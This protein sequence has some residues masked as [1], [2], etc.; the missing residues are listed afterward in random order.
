MTNVLVLFLDGVGL[1]KP[2]PQR[3]PFVLAQMPTLQRL[4]EGHRLVAGVAPID[5]REA[6]LLALDATLG[7]DGSP[8]S[9]SGQATLLTGLNV[10]AHIGE[11]YGPKP[12]PPIQ[13]IL[14]ADNLFKQVLKH[15]HT[16]A[17]LNAY[18]PGYFASI[19][20]GRRLYSAIPFAA[21]AAGLPLMTAA[22]LQSGRALSVDFTGEGWAA[23]P[24]F[25]PAPVYGA[26]HAGRL[27]AEL[28]SGF[29]LAWFD[30]WPSDYAGHKQDMTQAVSL[31]ERFDSV[32][33]GLVEAWRGEE[34]LIAITSDHGNLEDLGQRNHTRNLVPGLFIGPAELRQRFS[35]GMHDLSDFAP[36][37]MRLLLEGQPKAGA[38][39]GDNEHETGSAP[40]GSRADQKRG[41]E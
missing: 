8:Q 10:P 2:D 7:V 32:M 19:D 20:S 18:P 24:G 39:N 23:Q 38:G 22:D 31:L 33:A 11:H 25:P 41:E 5:G 30:F 1:G 4:L 9:A 13:D 36:A 14:E 21:N 15:G 12:N 27:L 37:V 6:T 17:L 3:N 26:K 29:D 34:G 35:Q 40:Q 28:A 16:A